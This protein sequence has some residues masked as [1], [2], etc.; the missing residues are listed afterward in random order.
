MK[1]KH[2]LYLFYNAFDLGIN[3]QLTTDKILATGGA[4]EAS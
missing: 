3:A 1:W 2:T 4:L